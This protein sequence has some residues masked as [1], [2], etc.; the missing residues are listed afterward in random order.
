MSA[1]YSWWADIFPDGGDG[2]DGGGGGGGSGVGV[3]QMMKMNM[4]F[5]QLQNAMQMESW[6]YNTVS[7]ALKVRHESS[8][9]AVRNMK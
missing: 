9:A 5:L 8:M 4:Q 2:P 6:K 3:Q 1:L 7:N